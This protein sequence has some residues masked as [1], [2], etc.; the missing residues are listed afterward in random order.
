MPVINFIDPTAV[1]PTEEGP[2]SWAVETGC[3]DQWETFDP[4]TQQL[5]IAWST[6]ILWALSGRRYGPCSVILRPCNPKCGQ[7]GGYMTFPVGQPG[8]SGS[9]QPWMI[10]YVDNGIWRNC[11]CTGGCSCR[12]ACEITLP[13]PVAAVNNV[14]I[15]GVELDP[16]AYRL[17]SYRGRDVLVRIDG[18]CW[19]DCQDMALDNDAVGAFAVTYSRGIAVPRAGQI[20]AGELACEFAK[21]CAGAAC[22][23]PQNLASL[24]RNGVEV[25]V[26][27][28]ETLLDQGLTGIANVDLWIRAVNPGRLAAP[29]RVFSSDVPG[30]RFV[31]P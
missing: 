19:P 27:D 22:T 7:Y 16:A 12:A 26:M 31:R 11:G 8:S 9:G 2:C 17:D 13:G 18:E 4:A 5:A 20:A 14:M 29:P 1:F 24:S 6:Y 25:T 28:P 15:D 21:A 23:L 30:E 10:P 3:C